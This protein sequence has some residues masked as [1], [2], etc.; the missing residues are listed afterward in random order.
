[1]IDKPYRL[2]VQLDWEEDSMIKALKDKHSINLSHLVKKTIKETYEKLE[3][4]SNG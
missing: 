3:G 2:T 4:L 1:M